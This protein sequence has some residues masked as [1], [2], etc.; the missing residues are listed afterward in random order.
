MVGPGISCPL[1]L[2]QLF[3]PLR[4]FKQGR[5]DS[6]SFKCITNGFVLDLRSL[7]HGLRHGLPLAFPTG[8]ACPVGWR[9]GRECFGSGDIEVPQFAQN[10]QQRLQ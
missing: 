5:S 6:R 8:V 1:G 3:Q 7:R 9:V 4:D 2:L 10:S